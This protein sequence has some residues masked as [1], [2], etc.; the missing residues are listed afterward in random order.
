LDDLEKSYS[1]SKDYDHHISAKR[2]AIDLKIGEPFRKGS[3]NVI[4]GKKSGKRR[5]EDAG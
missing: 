3:L 1:M 2:K 4:E 5:K